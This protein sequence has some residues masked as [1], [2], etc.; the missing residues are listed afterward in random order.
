MPFERG[1]G[2]ERDD[3]HVMRRAEAY[4]CRHL[5]GRLRPHTACG[6]RVGVVFS[7]RPCCSRSAMPVERRGPSRA[8]SA[9]RKAAGSAAGCRSSVAGQWGAGW[10]RSRTGSRGQVTPAFLIESRSRQVLVCKVQISVV[11]PLHTRHSCTSR[12]AAMP[13]GL[14]ASGCVGLPSRLLAVDAERG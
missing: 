7:P 9:D 2:S 13:L 14:P 10:V 8:V 5:L 1:S 12:A 3:R 11:H 6:G 4:D